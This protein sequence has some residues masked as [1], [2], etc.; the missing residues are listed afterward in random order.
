MDSKIFKIEETDTICRYEFLKGDERSTRMIFIIANLLF[1]VIIFLTIV[2]RLN[3]ANL[4]GLLVQESTSALFIGLYLILASLIIFLFLSFRLYQK[5][6]L[7]LLDNS[8]KQVKYRTL[9]NLRIKTLP[10]SKINSFKFISYENKNTEFKLE[11]KTIKVANFS[12]NSENLFNRI[13]IKDLRNIDLKDWILFLEDLEK[14]FS[15]NFT[16]NKKFS[17]EIENLKFERSYFKFKVNLIE[18]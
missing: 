15:K 13:S 16:I 17:D 12:F 2:G 8:L 9:F 10:L 11:K 6:Y 14:F 7:I 1:L 4:K 3:N 5:P 18:R